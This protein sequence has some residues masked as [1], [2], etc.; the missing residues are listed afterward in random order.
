MVQCDIEVPRDWPDPVTPKRLGTHLCPREYFA[1]FPPIMKHADV[2]INDIGETMKAFVQNNN[3]SEKPRRMLI[4]SYF[5]NNVLLATPMIQ[6]L[7]RHGLEITRI[8]AVIEYERA[9][10]FVAKAEDICN[11]RRAGD[12][13]PTLAIL[14]DMKKT[15][16]NSFY[17]KSITAQESQLDI[18]YMATLKASRAINSPFFQALEAL[19]D[20]DDPVHEVTSFKKFIKFN[21]PIQIGFFTYQ[22]AKLRMLQFLYDC[23]DRY[24]DRSDYQLLESDTDSFYMAISADSIFAVIKPHLRE[25]FYHNY[26]QWFP[27]MACSVHHKEW[28]SCMMRGGTWNAPDCCVKRQAFE[29]RTPELF[30]VEWE[31]QGFIGLCSK[32]YYCWGN[33]SD[34]YA[35]KGVNKHRNVVNKNTFLDVLRSQQSHRVENSGF[36]MVNGRMM[37]YTQAKSGMTYNYWKRVV[38][39]DG[40]ATEPLLL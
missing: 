30:K 7:L 24:I 25:E 32:T 23:I 6:W 17:G 8:H 39:P 40:I 19:E 26:N 11:A 4:A 36:R 16:G 31:G 9:T 20:S 35:A 3:L 34:K 33:D 13:D 18:K 28:S 38:L 22:L 21:L 10:P 1:E 14:A 29:K 12:A 2:T 5:G 27:A 15:T 37:T